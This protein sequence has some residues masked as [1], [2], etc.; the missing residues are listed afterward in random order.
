MKK[1][2]IFI[3][4]VICIAITAIFIGWNYK[5]SL[6]AHFLSKQLNHVPVELSNL[7]L[8]K[9]EA[10][11]F[12]LHI[13]TPKKSKTTTS[14]DTRLITVNA[15]LQ[16]LRANPLTVQE[17]SMNDIFIGIEYYNLSGS[18]NNWVQILAKKKTEEKKA[19]SKKYLIKKLTLRNLTVQVT[20]FQGKVTRYP[21]LDK[22]EFYDISDETGFPIDDIEKA[23]LN[24]VLRAAFQKLG[25]DFLMESI[26]PSKWVPGI[27]PFFGMSEGK[28]VD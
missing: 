2:F 25:L 11:I 4:I 19:T 20:D 6:F 24:A 28:K 5:T 12:D 7:K 17:I 16:N 1:F 3:L 8:T 27:I 21:T 9:T 18:N 23:I 26:S 10:K 14:L 22:L 13:G 15:T